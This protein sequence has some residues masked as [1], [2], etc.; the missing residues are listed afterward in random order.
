MHC[1]PSTNTMLK[2][3]QGRLGWG[4]SRPL[5]L[6][7]ARTDHILAPNHRSTRA[8][9]AKAPSKTRSLGAAGGHSAWSEC[10]RAL[11]RRLSA[12][13]T[14]DRRVP[15]GRAGDRTVLPSPCSRADDAR[16][17]VSNLQWARGACLRGL[18]RRLW[19][20]GG[21]L[22]NSGRLR[23]APGTS[24][25]SR[26]TTAAGK[27]RDPLFR[28]ALRAPRRRSFD[29]LSVGVDPEPPTASAEAGARRPP[30]WLDRRVGHAARNGSLGY[31]PGAAPRPS[32]AQRVLVARH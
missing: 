24:G 9:L 3:S 14:R 17:R 31:D 27:G 15:E 12:R 20:G 6:T 28:R 23:S 29:A 32:K 1:A 30:L 19:T 16:P 8:S 22:R 2:Q 25:A 21:V 4:E 13:P 26:P 18:A 7:N 5:R 10:R 11:S